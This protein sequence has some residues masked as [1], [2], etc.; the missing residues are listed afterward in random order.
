[1]CSWEGNVEAGTISWGSLRG[2][3]SS[4][5]AGGLQPNV[6]QTSTEHLESP[7]CCPAVYEGILPEV[8]RVSVTWSHF[9]LTTVSWDWAILIPIFSLQTVAPRK[10]RWR[11]GRPVADLHR[12][13]FSF[14]LPFRWGP[15]TIVV[16]QR[17]VFRWYHLV[18]S[19]S[20]PENKSYSSVRT[21]ALTVVDL[22][23]K[24]T[25]GKS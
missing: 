19:F 10:R 9:Y 25:G 8:K 14:N 7:A 21:E 17:A 13:L 20:S 16:L 24:R 5:S 1:M 22:I 6:W 11:C 23:V 18:V 15:D 2:V 4:L 3:C 12:H